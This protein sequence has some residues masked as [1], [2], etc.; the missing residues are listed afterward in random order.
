G[1]ASQFFDQYAFGFNLSW[2]IDFWGRFRRAV[3]AAEDT[4]GASCAN[5]GYVLMTL[6]AD[7][8]SNYLQVRTLQQRI[9][10]VRAN[11]DLQQGILGIADRRLKAGKKGATD[12]HQSRSTLAQTES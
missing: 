3:R 8:A 2:E 9:A 10:Y 11:V 5:Y 6:R 1:F 12:V 4:L 7:V